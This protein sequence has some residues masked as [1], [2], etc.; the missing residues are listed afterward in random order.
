MVIN[1]NTTP[2]TV[3]LVELTCPF[4]RNIEAA[5]VKKSLRCKFLAADIEEAA[6]YKCSNVPFEIGIEG[7][8]D[9]K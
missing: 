3:L 6:V 5:N 9:P 2:V 1:T 4:T 7:S 8:R